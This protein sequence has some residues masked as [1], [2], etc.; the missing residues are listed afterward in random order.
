MTIPAATGGAAALVERVA[1]ARDGFAR[2]GIATHEAQADAEVLARH[3][4]GW[5]RA[6][7][8]ARRREP[9]PDGF[10]IRYAPLAARRARREPVSTITGRREFWGLGFEVGPAVLTPRPATELIVETVLDLLRD[11]RDAPLA[12]ADAGTGSGCLAVTLA[13]EFPRAAVT[14]IDISPA[15]LAVAR[16]NAVAHG[17]AGRI[18]WIEAPFEDWFSKASAN[19]TG[20]RIDMLVANLPY[21]PTRELDAL[22][23]EIRLYEPRVALDGGPDGLDPLRALLPA[24]PRRLNPDARVVIEIGMGQAEALDALAAATHG[25][26]LREIRTDLQGVPRTAVFA[27]A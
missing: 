20:A 8:L 17:V 21:V 13:R 23:P 22:P 24:A 25:V 3:A 4:L 1:M 26:A 6:T 7:Y 19:D 5:D 16:R 11:R 9:A 15:A 18:A 10:E 27:A 2:A 14:A 12:I